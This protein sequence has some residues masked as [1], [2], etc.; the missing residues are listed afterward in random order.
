MGVK[1]L[2]DKGEWE[3]DKGKKVGSHPFSG[4]PFLVV[5]QQILR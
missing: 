4:R 5:G 3:S 2:M 1:R